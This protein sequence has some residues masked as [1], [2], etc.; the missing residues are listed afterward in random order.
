[1]LFYIVNNKL[2]IYFFI[3][4]NKGGNYEYSESDEDELKYKDEIGNTND[5]NSDKPAPEGI[6]VYF[7]FFFLCQQILYL[8]QQ[9]KT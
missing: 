6:H 2:I 1:M 5:G 3:I 8:C 4:N 7:C 9:G